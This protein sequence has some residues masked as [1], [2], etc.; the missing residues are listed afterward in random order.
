MF[1]C[2]TDA[3]AL[4]DFLGHIIINGMNILTEGKYLGSSNNHLNGH[5]LGP[6][7]VFLALQHVLCL[8]NWPSHHSNTSPFMMF[9]E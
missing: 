4:M 5:F 9:Y 7:V 8:L 2:N 3:A 6:T 1:V